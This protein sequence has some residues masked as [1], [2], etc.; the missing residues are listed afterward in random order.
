MEQQQL[1]HNA[2]M[3]L[4]G[5]EN[6]ADNGD[7]TCHVPLKFDDTIRHPDSLLDEWFGSEDRLTRDPRGPL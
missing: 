5:Q 4:A 2:T 6:D 7:F 1:E 3:R